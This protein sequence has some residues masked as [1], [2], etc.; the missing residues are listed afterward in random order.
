[1]Y[2][3]KWLF[4]LMYR[5]HIMRH[6]GFSR[7]DGLSTDPWDLGRHTLQLTC[8]VRFLKHWTDPA[9]LMNFEGIRSHAPFY[10]TKAP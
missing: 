6:T 9:P 1:M 10:L 7:V 8:Q 4:L 2:E 5:S 3:P